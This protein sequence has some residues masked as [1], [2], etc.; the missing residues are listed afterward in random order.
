MATLPS[1]EAMG[2]AGLFEF[3]GFYHGVPKG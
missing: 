2:D 3:A 1:E